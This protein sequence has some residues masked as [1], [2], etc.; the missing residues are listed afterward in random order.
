MEVLRGATAVLSQDDD[1]VYF[2]RQNGRNATEAAGKINR[3]FNEGQ[4]TGIKEYQ[5][6]APTPGGVAEIAAVP[7]DVRKVSDLPKD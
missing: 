1:V 6:Q 7:P 3:G 2:E 5:K 4:A